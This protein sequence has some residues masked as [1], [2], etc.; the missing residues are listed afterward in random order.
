M[1]TSKLT[2]SGHES[3]HCRALWLKKG[4]DFLANQR[5][6]RDPSAVVYLGVGK[7]MVSSIQYWTKAF[8]LVKKEN[9]FSELADFLFGTN[10]I[11]P[12]LENIAS[13]WLLHFHLVTENLASIYSLIFNDFRKKRIEF[14]RAQVLHFIA[15]KCE[16][17]NT[18]FNEKTVQR[19]ISVFLRNYVKPERTN[20]NIEE[21][22]SGL[23]VDLNLIE[24]MR[25]FGEEEPE[26]YKIESR[27]RT[28]LPAE[29]V[30]Y[31]ILSNPDYGDSILFDE[32]LVGPNS[33][34]SVFA[35]SSKGLLEKIGQLTKSSKSI[36][37]T[38]HAGVRVLQLSRRVD[39]WN[40]L[41]RYYEK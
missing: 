35:I 13:L 28:D 30:L 23:F 26:W 27:D 36:T 3:F 37:F 31:G 12:Y 14:S 15:R 34:G 4:Y 40:I 5:E 11:D 22:F 18:N 39:K 20:K 25:R 8:G 41:R 7:N 9:S 38:D 10:G 33:V 2:F 21:L 24:T 6:F 1:T 17:A 16:E 29:A 32:L 19:D